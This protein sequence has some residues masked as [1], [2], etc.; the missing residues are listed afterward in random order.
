MDCRLCN[1]YTGP[2]SDVLLHRTT[3]D[4]EVDAFEAAKAA[5][6]TSGYRATV[7]EALRE[8]ARAAALRRAAA[9]LRVGD[10]RLVRPEDVAALR[11]PPV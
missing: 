8:V 5:L 3:I 4:I 10:D 6:G 7:N 1:R 9:A 2:V 11:R